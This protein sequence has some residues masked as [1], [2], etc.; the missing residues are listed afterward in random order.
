MQ[1]QFMFHIPA[2]NSLAKIAFVWNENFTNRFDDWSENS[3]LVGRSGFTSGNSHCPE[4]GSN[5][6]NISYETT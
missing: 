5:D 2:N 3:S 4:F 6:V 1:K